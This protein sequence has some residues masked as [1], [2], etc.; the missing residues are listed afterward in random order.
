MANSRRLTSPRT[1]EGSLFLSPVYVC[2]CIVVLYV[3]D[4]MLVM[5]EKQQENGVRAPIGE[6]RTDS[7]QPA[8]SRWTKTDVGTNIAPING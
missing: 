2:V 8:G 1:Q 4:V 5:H 6:A 7:R 3:R